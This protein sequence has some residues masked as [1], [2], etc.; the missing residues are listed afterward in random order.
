MATEVRMP[1]AL[2]LMAEKLL[3]VRA[4]ALLLLTAAA[5]VQ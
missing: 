1:S 5:T 4:P 2:L 3:L